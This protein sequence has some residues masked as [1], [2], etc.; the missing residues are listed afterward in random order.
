MSDDVVDTRY[1]ACWD[2]STKIDELPDVGSIEVL[3]NMMFDQFDNKLEKS[4]YEEYDEIAFDYKK[5][6]CAMLSIVFFESSLVR[7]KQPV[8]YHI[9]QICTEL[10]FIIIGGSVEKL[11]EMKDRKLHDM[12][13]CVQIMKWDPISQKHMDMSSEI[14]Y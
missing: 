5:D 10:G 8:S 11:I 12:D 1:I 6:E 14:L 2:F 13:T 9:S 7:F 3:T 4:D